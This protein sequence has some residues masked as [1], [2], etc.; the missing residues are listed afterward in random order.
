[1]HCPVGRAEQAVRG[2]TEQAGFLG[3][4]WYFEVHDGGLKSPAGDGRGGV[5]EM[6][7]GLPA[8]RAVHGAAMSPRREITLR[9]LASRMDCPKAML[10]M[11]PYSPTPQPLQVVVR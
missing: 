3:G 5:R 4:R 10:A 2:A 11:R 1:M 8:C 9:A 6:A 7:D